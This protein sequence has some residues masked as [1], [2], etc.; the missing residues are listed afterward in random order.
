V[1]LEDPEEGSGACGPT[2]AQLERRG[3]KSR[4]FRWI[5]E[6]IAAFSA[7]SASED[8]HSDDQGRNPNRWRTFLGNLEISTF[9]RA[10]QAKILGKFLR[11]PDGGITAL[12]F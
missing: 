12:C 7:H 2:L 9:S 5:S 4:D 6:N 8:E 3:R 11:A 1:A 10:P